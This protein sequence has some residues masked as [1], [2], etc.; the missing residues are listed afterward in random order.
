[1]KAALKNREESQAAR[2]ASAQGKNGVGGEAV[3]TAQEKE[4]L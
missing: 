3:G 4:E 2:A 1:M